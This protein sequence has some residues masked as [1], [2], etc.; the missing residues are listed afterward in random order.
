ML[1][2][3]ELSMPGSTLSYPVAVKQLKDKSHGNFC[4]EVKVMASFNHENILRL[5]GVVQMGTSHICL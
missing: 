1:S 2:L 3:G 5:I 4:H